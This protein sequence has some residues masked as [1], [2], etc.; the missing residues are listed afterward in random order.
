M[1]KPAH[2]SD[3]PDALPE[4]FKAG[5]GALHF[6][7]VSAA[8]WNYTFV[9]VTVIPNVTIY[10]AS[11]GFISTP[12]PRYCTW[13]HVTVLYEYGVLICGHLIGSLSRQEVHFHDP[14]PKIATPA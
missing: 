8:L 12:F 4:R 3:P 14:L 10:P 13:G 2:L 11:I 5:D 9:V 7:T 1:S 6:G